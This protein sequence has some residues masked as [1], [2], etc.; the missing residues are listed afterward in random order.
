MGYPPASDAGNVLSTRTQYPTEWSKRA[1][2]IGIALAVLECLIAPYNDFVIR[3][4]F[5]AGGH[6]PARPIFCPDHLGVG[7]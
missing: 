2:I 4:T 3:N 1:L 5:L 7:C 6:F